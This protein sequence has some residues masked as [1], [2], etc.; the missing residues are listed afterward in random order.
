MIALTNSAANWCGGPQMKIKMHFHKIISIVK[1]NFSPSNKVRNILKEVGVSVLK[2]AIK[3]LQ[4][5][6]KKVTKYWQQTTGLPE[7]I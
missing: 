7:N 6:V 4:K 1:N 3:W 5:V 2:S